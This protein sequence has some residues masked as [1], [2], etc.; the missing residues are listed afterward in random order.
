[1]Q[2]CLQ[3]NTVRLNFQ[4]FAQNISETKLPTFDLPYTNHFQYESVDRPPLYVLLTFSEHR[5][6]ASTLIYRTLPIDPYL[7]ST[8]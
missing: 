4:E 1:M 6:L 7:T 8:K 2:M 3:K 5:E